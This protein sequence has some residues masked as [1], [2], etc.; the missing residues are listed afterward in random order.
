MDKNAKAGLVFLALGIAN[1]LLMARNATAVRYDMPTTVLHGVIAAMLLAG[2]VMF[3]RE[4]R[5]I[6]TR[7]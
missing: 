1:A 4:S 5:S 3:F 7:S 6:V 2:A